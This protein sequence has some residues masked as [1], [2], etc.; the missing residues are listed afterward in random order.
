VANTARAARKFKPSQRKADQDDARRLAQLPA[1]G[2]RPAVAV[3]TRPTRPW[4]AR[5]AGRQRLVGRR[6]AAPNRSRAGP[7]GTARPAPRGARAWAALGLAGLAR[8]ARPLA[9]GAAGAR[10]RGLLE[11]ALSEYRQAPGLL[12]QAAAKLDPLAKA[13][14]GV[15]RLETSPGVGPR[16]AAAVV[17][18]RGAAGRFATGQPVSACAGLVPRPYPSGACARRGRLSRRGPARLGKLLVECAG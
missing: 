3:P 11:L 15:R 18:C 4:R 6:G 9:D 13:A 5:I 10:W 14:A 1:L 17:A 12:E 7:T 8:H 2:Q 16:P